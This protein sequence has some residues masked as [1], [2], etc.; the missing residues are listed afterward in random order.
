MVLHG[1]GK[2]DEDE[3]EEEEDVVEFDLDDA[4]DQGEMRFLAMVR[5]YSGKKFNVRGLFEE[6]RVSWGLHSMKPVQV[7]GDNMFMLEFDSEWVKRRVVDGRPWRHR[8]DALIVV[9][10]DGFS[11]PSPVEI[12]TIGLWVRFY[13]MP[14]ALRKEEYAHKLGKHL[15][16]VQRADLSYPNYVRVR[17]M[18]PL[19]NALVPETKVR[20]RGRGDM[21][22][23]I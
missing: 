22:V 19:A 10:Y 3:D 12:N 8:G 5:F 23:T 14:L 18:F 17:V 21:K 16:E 9:S 4:D 7:L 11:P 13:D 6:M 15:G 2:Q 1:M 20:I